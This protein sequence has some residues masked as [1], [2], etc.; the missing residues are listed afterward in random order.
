M[1]FIIRWI[2]TAIA[3]AVAVWLVPGLSA[4]GGD[5]TVGIAVFSLVLALVNAIVKPVLQFL[6]IPITVLTLGIFYIVVNALM[7]EL[8]SWAAGGMFGTGVQVDGF[9]S[10]FLG[11]IIISIVSAIV[12]GLF[13]KDRN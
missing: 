1:N 13:G 9:G 6:S 5:A 4:T 7:I 12:N 11:A 10:A 8:A 3:A 2:V